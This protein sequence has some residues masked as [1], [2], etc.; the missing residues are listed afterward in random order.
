MSTITLTPI[1]FDLFKN[2]A[3]F[4]FDFTVKMGIV[5]VIADT[6]LLASLGY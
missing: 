5:H 4:Y 2:I 1:E 3:D 6:K